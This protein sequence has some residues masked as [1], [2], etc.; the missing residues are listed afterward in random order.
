MFYEPLWFVILHITKKDILR[1][2][3]KLC[4]G[5]KQM[6]AIEKG[7]IPQQSRMWAAEECPACNSTKTVID[8]STGYTICQKCGLVIY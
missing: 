5:A 2:A 8:Y 7:L 3:V 4:R 6:G 1:R